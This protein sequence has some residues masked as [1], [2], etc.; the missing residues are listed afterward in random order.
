MNKE[1]PEWLK[2]S[3]S[4]ILSLDGLFHLLEM[5]IALYEEA[6]LTASVVG[7]VAIIMFTSSW[8]LRNTH[9]DD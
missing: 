2:S 8:V 5:G 3:L 9:E 4:F 1:I 7:F 6:Y